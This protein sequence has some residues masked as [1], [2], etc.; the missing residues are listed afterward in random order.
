M[1]L[2]RLYQLFLNC[3]VALLC[4]TISLNSFSQVRKPGSINMNGIVHGYNYDGAKRLLKKQ[5]QIVLEG[6]LDKVYIVASINGDLVN[7]TYSKKNGTF[8][9]YIPV[10]DIYLIT[11][12]KEAYTG[13]SFYLNLSDV[14]QE[15]ADQGLIFEGAEVLL[16]SHVSRKKEEDEK[17]FGTVYYDNSIN[18]L[19]F[20]PEITTRKKSVYNKE[21]EGSSPIKLMQRSIIK[22]SNNNEPGAVSYIEEPVSTPNYRRRVRTRYVTDTVFAVEDSV[23][24]VRFSEFSLGANIGKVNYT[25]GSILSR[26]EEIV[27][28]RIQLEQDKLLAVTY[29]DSMLLVA[30]ENLIIAA[31]KELQGAKEHI[32]IQEEAISRKNSI[33]YLLGG[34]LLIITIFSYFLFRLNKI[35]KSINA[36]LNQRNRH[37]TSSINYAKRIQESTLLSDKEIAAIFPKS[38]VMSMPKDTVSGDFH[39]FSEVQGFKIAVACDCTGHGVPGA[40]MS[41]IGSILLNEIV[42]DKKILNPAKIL[43]ELHT[44]VV[45]SLHQKKGRKGSQDGMELSVCVFDEKNKKMIFSGAVNSLYLIKNSGQIEIIKADRRSIGGVVRRK[46][47]KPFTNHEIRF[48]KGDKFYMMSDGYMDQFGGENEEK[49]NI[50]R[51]EKLL[52]EVKRQSMSRQKEL[53]K[54]EIIK[55]MGDTKQIDD[56]LIVGIEM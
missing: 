2:T 47:P 6:T 19:A 51:F 56:M 25:E 55:W 24:E 21:V 27:N 22:N 46:Q 4:I 26:E 18:A 43:E 16:N 39:W 53:F 33:L 49:F 5:K 8:E 1:K 9:M 44:Q 32:K 34:V 14:P 11:L 54:N 12:S 15:I 41:L 48:E 13:T 35:R 42:N 50:I 7:A 30:R 31:E 28:A 36:K 40:F 37:I 17:P 45:K 10:G 38:F 3:C 29:K 52:K 20:K 23:E